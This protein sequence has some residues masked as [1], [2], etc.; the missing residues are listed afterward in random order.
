MTGPDDGGDEC[1]ISPMMLPPCQPPGAGQ[2][3]V[4]DAMGGAVG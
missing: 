3:L 2:P 4:A 1:A